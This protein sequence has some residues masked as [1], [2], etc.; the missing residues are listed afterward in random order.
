MGIGHNGI[1]KYR[2]QGQYLPVPIYR[3]RAQVTFVDNDSTYIY[4]TVRAWFN[5]MR[6]ALQGRPVKAKLGNLKDWQLYEGHH[7]TGG[8]I[9]Y[10]YQLVNNRLG[11]TVY[12]YSIDK[13]KDSPIM[14]ILHGKPWD[15]STAFSFFRAANAHAPSTNEVGPEPTIVEVSKRWN[16][17]TKH[18]WVQVDVFITGNVFEAEEAVKYVFGLLHRPVELTFNK[19]TIPRIE[20]FIRVHEVAERAI[21]DAMLA[22]A[23]RWG[24]N[25]TL[26]EVKHEDIDPSTAF[27]LGYWATWLFR[28]SGIYLSPGQRLD[29]KLYRKK[30]YRY[31]AE[32]Y[33]DHPKMEVAAYHVP[34]EPGA[35]KRVEKEAMELIAS[36][37]EAAN[38][39]D[40]IVADPEHPVAGQGL[41]N[42]LIVAAINKEDIKRR[43]AQF[44]PV[45]ALQLDDKER[46]IL[47]QALDRRLTSQ[48]LKR[49]A[50]TLGVSTRTVQLK[51]KALVDKGLLLRFRTKRNQWIYLFDFDR[52]R[53]REM[54]AEPSQPVQQALK[55]ALAEV[56]ELTPAPVQGLADRV[57]ATYILIRHGYRT[58][59]AIAR[60]LGVTDRQVR[61]YIKQLREAGLVEVEKRGRHVFYSVAAHPVMQAQPAQQAE[62]EGEALDGEGLG[63]EPGATVQGAGAAAFVPSAPAPDVGAAGGGGKWK[64]RR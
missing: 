53:P 10:V 43:F 59:K 35:V 31:P 8:K 27:R 52:V 48:D 14:F 49:I 13:N 12:T 15:N 29:L 58:T 37:I 6:A 18:V 34:F 5:S 2:S 40:A 30:K 23:E 20:L 42:P 47:M 3:H 24:E 50:Q 60:I 7:R 22:L 17:E 62:A 21:K 38:A 63:P 25:K 36:V 9:K 41:P 56:A 39:Y 26:I 54:V 61:N 1:N 4:N 51:V 44:A 46:F 33:T 64:R 32:D 55:E 45:E 57:Q 16:K 19:T 11:V 28:I